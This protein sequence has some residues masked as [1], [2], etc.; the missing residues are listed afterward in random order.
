M[1]PLLLRLVLALGVAVI[2]AWFAITGYVRTQ[3]AAD[4]R[5][6][7]QAVAADGVDHIERAI[8]GLGTREAA[9][10]AEEVA[11]ALGLQLSWQE[12][13][14]LRGGPPGRARGG[15]PPFLRW[16][17]GG[18]PDDRGP[19]PP[20][21]T[22]EGA[23]ADGTPFYVRARPMGPPDSGWIAVVPPLAFVVIILVVSWLVLLRPLTRQGRD[24][25]AAIS[26]FG[27]EQWAARAPTQGPL[28]EVAA[29]FNRTAERLE[30][31]VTT[32]RQVFQAVSHELRTPLARARFRAEALRDGRDGAEVAAALEADIDEMEHLVEEVVAFLR[33]DAADASPHNEP[34]DVAAALRRRVETVRAAG[35]G[36]DLRCAGPERLDTKPLAPQRWVLRAVDNL[37]SNARKYARARVDL[38]FSVEPSGLVV[39]VHDDGPG[40]PVAERGRVTEPF[41]SADASRG[42]GT[43]LGL[44]L[45]I[46]QR[47]VDRTGGSLSIGESDL[48]GAKVVLGFPVG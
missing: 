27:A 36:P 39:E 12:P 10:R 21:G 33:Y 35:P 44:G 16:D 28:A 6:S 20:F 15:P 13:P 46:V 4:R 2:A 32:Q 1:K 8:V 40:I 47:I 11:A 23:L 37:L 9:P 38:R 31:L 5:E 41:V 19:G 29:D 3:V 18:P 45:A 43:G 30:R 42:A 25:A 48:G 34:W 7:A 24:L 26:A 17:G 14:P 22:V